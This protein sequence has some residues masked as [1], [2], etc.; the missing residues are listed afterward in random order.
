VI[1]NR[2]VLY[3]PVSDLE[4]IYVWDEFDF[5]H[6]DQ[7][8]PYGHSRDI[9]LIRQS[10]ENCNLIF[11]S[12]SMS[13]E[14]ARLVEMGFLALQTESNRRPRIS[15]EEDSQKA[16]ALAIRTIRNGLASGPVLI[17]VSALGNSVALY[18]NDCQQKVLCVTC[19][20]PLWL[21]SSNKPV[22]RW[23]NA[24]N[25]N[26]VCLHC[27]GTKIKQ[28]RAGATRSVSEYGRAFPGFAI[29]ES[30]STNRLK[31]VSSK[32]QLVISTAGCEP[33]A[34]K[35]YS[36]IVFADARNQVSWDSL[37]SI[38]DAV[39]SWG[40]AIQLLAEGGSAALIGIGG[41][42]AEQFALWQLFEIARDQYAERCELGL[43]PNVRLASVT[44]TIENA[45]KVVDAVDPELAIKL[46][47]T[48][49]V[50]G[51]AQFLLKYQYKNGLELASILKAEQLKAGASRRASGTGNSRTVR[52][53]MDDRQVI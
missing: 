52:I 48:S 2:N 26:L 24:L 18:C 12:T 13:T 35:G 32:P 19:S 16:N 39:H 53:K 3:S 22:C 25:Y 40:G 15:F 9:A 46:G 6:T 41:K 36:A 51:S 10:V 20:G 11:A 30:T 44:G 1:G 50:D 38:E 33:V 7:A 5:S 45:S 43:P 14:I 17:Q 4:S 28:G 49:L 27:R 23:C 21:D 8:A 47:P 42:L 34:E 37:R 31:N 29:H